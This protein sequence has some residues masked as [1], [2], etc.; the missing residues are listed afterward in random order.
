MK[1]GF[2]LPG[3]Y[4]HD[5]N[6]RLHQHIEEQAGSAANEKI[7]ASSGF[8]VPDAYFEN[9]QVD[10]DQE[11]S[12]FTRKAQLAVA[13]ILLIALSIGI[14]LNPFASSPKEIDFSN[15]QD[16]Q[17]DEYIDNRDIN[18]EIVEEYINRQP[19]N[20]KLD[21]AIQTVDKKEIFNYFN[22]QLN[23]LYAY[24]E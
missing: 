6:K 12:T 4:W 2:Q 18:Q 11:K 16:N 23:D 19:A 1:S 7:E 14:T 17:I 10:V 22:D 20:F 8:Q 9:F 15:I 21:E 5:F 3:N 13:A 24:E